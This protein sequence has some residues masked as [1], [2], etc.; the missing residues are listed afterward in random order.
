MTFLS[1][2]A[3][4]LT[5]FL[6]VILARPDIGVRATTGDSTCSAYMCVTAVVN[7]TSVEYTLSSTGK[8][9]TGWMGMGFGSQMAGTEMV[10]MWANSDG[11]IT[12][13]QRKA[14]GEVMPTV[15][16]SP[17]RL[18]T[19]S[20]AL[21]TTSGNPS[22][23]YTIPPNS[24]TEQNIIYAFGNVAPSSS[25][26]DA[27]LQ[28]HL[29]SESATLDLTK[30]SSTS[31]S[32]GASSSPTS[33]GGSSNTGAG[34]SSSSGSGSVT[35]D[36]PLTPWQR[37]I[38]AHAIFCVVGF[39]LFLPAGAL[40]ARYL[41]TYTPSW[42]TGHWIAQFALAGPVIIVG[43]ILGIVSVGK[44][45]AIHLNDTHKKWGIAIF[46]L[47]FVQCALGAVIHWV[48]PKN[49]TRRPLQNY[50]HAILG[51]FLIGISLYQV[52][53]GIK[54]EWPNTTGR[55]ELPNSTNIVW[56]VWVVL[57]PV[58][59]ALGLSL[60]PR[61]Y[62]QE[63]QARASRGRSYSMSSVGIKPQGEYRD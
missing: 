27:T 51:L 3:S 48:K 46:V 41:R 22:F 7:E 54:T 25:E 28:Q 57:L 26:A 38:V 50:L 62:Q 13:S 33:S 12:L 49:A 14:T 5:F 4:L 24:A 34:G 29:D 37:L 17:T 11:S 30:S 18:A 52:R 58:L 8:V 1:P 21:S 19:L 45:G 39:L 15:D 35:D 16:S 47:Y 53:S 10:I 61:Q 56:Y 36:I 2:L 44:A 31:T 9:T 20:N 6:F 63:K 42:Y 40:L 23:V 32:S 43:V 55:G 59:Y 60:L